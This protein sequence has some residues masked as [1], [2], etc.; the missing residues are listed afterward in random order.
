MSLNADLDALALIVA[1]MVQES[2]SAQ[3]FDAHQ[4][5]NKWIAEPL[6]ALGGRY[7]VDVLAEP[8]GFE[9]IRTILTRMQSGAYC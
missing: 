2:G 5:L 7:P 6:P 9:L 4:W 1:R 8:G 3:A